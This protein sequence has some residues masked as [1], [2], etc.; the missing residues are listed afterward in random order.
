M[1]PMLARSA[2]AGQATF[3]PEDDDEDPDDEDEE[4]EEEEEDDDELLTVSADFLPALSPEPA[5]ASGFLLSDPFADAV[6]GSELF[7]LAR[8]SVR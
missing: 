2:T 3:E 4:E 7:W 8:L 1:T 5:E 6:A